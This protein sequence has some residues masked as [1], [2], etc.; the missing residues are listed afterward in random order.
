MGFAL[1]NAWREIRNNRAFCLFYIVNLALGLIGFISVD[2]F[3][4]TLDQR[5][6]AESKELL[7]ADLAIRARR[8]ITQEEL[9]AVRDTLPAGTQEIEAVDFFS[10]VAG[11]TGR[12]RLVKIVAFDPGFPFYGTFKTNLHNSISGEDENLIHERPLA[13]LYPELRGQLDIDLGEKLQVGETTFIISDLVK[14]ESGLSFQAA[15]LAPKVF[16]S[17]NFLEKTKLL[18]QGNTAF[19]NHLFKLPY[20]SDLAEVNN[21]VRE[22]LT[23]PEVRVYSHERVGHRAGRLL[24]YLSDFL[25]LV[26]LVALFL[27][28]LGI[29]YLYQG[30]INN[31]TKDVAILVCLGAPVG[32]ALRTYLIQLALLGVAAALPAIVLCMIAIPVLSQ[33]L[34]GFVPVQLD[35]TLHLPSILL[36]LAVAV[37]GGWFLALPSLRKIR[38]LRPAELFQESANPSASASRSSLLFA[39][40]GILAFWGLCVLQ[41]DSSKL[42]NLFFLSLLGSIIVLYFIGHICLWFLDRFFRKSSLNLRLAARS[43]TRNPKSA[44]TGF[45]TLGLGVLLLNLIPQFQYSLENE[46][47][48]NS[49]ESKIPKLFLFDIQEDQVEDLLQTLK[50]SGKPLQNLTPWIRGKLIEVRGEQYENL[51]KQDREFENPEDQRRNN[52]RNRGFNLSYR[53]HLLESEEILRGRMVTMNFD[54]NSSQPAEISVEQKYAESLGLDLGD[55]IKIEVSGLPVEAV[56]VNIRRVRWTSFQPNFFVQMQPGVLEGAPKTFIGTLNQ[57][58]T[59]EKQ[60]IQDILVRKFPTISILDVERTGRKILEIVAQ[61]TWALQV[62]AGLS[63]LAGLVVLYSL[64]REKARRQKRELN[65]LKI[66]GASFAD[67]KAQV[68]IEFGLLSLSASCLGIFLS[69]GTSYLLAEKVFDRVWSLQ[70]SLPVTIVAGVFALSLLV[71]ELATRKIL[72][73][74]PISILNQ[75]H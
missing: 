21:E 19:R 32:N 65:L 15:E 24:R 1:R 42:A 71:T 22:A 50:L 11:P 37:F 31:R 2:S 23:S 26:S 14:D 36:A 53:N 75:R 63:I 9:T 20:G 38:S 67:L 74:K 18:S 27:A 73:E 25:G 57:L 39:I 30:F 44:V 58:T 45:L 51:V 59:V 3:K 55:R 6:E 69:L 66:L 60:K 28:T 52:F 41:S 68:R 70:W 43:L 12:S 29:G 10:M 34:S 47:G 62:M 72:K 61:M 8:E 33:A 13:W 49:G 56:V 4:Q 54:Q 16:V 64:A 48:A 40:P 17:K 46:I 7:G 35:A 5:V